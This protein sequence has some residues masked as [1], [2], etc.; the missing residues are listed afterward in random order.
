MNTIELLN[1]LQ[2]ADFMVAL[3]Q[4]EKEDSLLKSG[5]RNNEDPTAS[6]GSFRRCVKCKNVRLLGLFPLVCEDDPSDCRRHKVCR[7][8]LGS[9]LDK[10]KFKKEAP[11][12]RSV[13]RAKNTARTR[14]YSLK[15]S[16]S[17]PRWADAEE[18]QK[19]YIKSKE[20]TLSTGVKHQV[21]H[22]VPLTH[23]FVCGL[24]IPANL[25]VITAAEN[26]RKT[27]HFEIA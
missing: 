6:P 7:V 27:N 14:A 26:L 20:L 25:R 19:F 12:R 8:C 3:A 23:E 11:A 4:G 9:A 1:E 13:A 18:I 5:R 15:K 24:H 17:M 2:V 22:I 21:D 10:A 16:Q